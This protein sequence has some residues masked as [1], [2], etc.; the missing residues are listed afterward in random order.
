M[1]KT[2][3]KLMRVALTFGYDIDNAL[4]WLRIVI[5]AGKP[6]FFMGFL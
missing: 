1:S 2:D 4:I 6:R 3:N 5:V